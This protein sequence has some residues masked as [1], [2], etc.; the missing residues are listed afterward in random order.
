MPHLPENDDE[1]RVPQKNA[2]EWTVFAA[3]AVLVLGTLGYLIFSAAT[4]KKLPPVLSIALGQAQ[5]AASQFRVPVTISND[6][7]QTATG[8]QIEVTLDEGK[9]GEEKASFTAPYL[10]RHSKREGAVL[11]KSDPRK[12]KLQARVLGYVDP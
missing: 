11:F 8:V 1:M 12:G 5:P 2:L 9:P 10:P 4:T 6:G 7:N 3:S